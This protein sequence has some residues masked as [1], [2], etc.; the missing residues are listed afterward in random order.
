M[1]H[2]ESPL[3]VLGRGP[4][5]GFILALYNSRSEGSSG[6][7]SHCSY[8]KPYSI[9][10]FFGFLIARNKNKLQHHVLAYLPSFKTL[11]IRPSYQIAAL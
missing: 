3:Y 9:S 8:G 10:Q 7:V 5:V 2:H 1:S 4:A 6:I 11:A